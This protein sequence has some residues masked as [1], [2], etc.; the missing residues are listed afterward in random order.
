MDFG[1]SVGFYLAQE[2]C[3]KKWY[4]NGDCEGISDK[5][6]V[7]IEAGEVVITCWANSCNPV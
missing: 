2:D 3:T 6:D 4:S 7:Y 5:C 1:I